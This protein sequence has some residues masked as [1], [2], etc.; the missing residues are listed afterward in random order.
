MSADHIERIG[1]VYFATLKVP[2][3]LRELLGRHKFK[4]TT[5]TG[6]RRRAKEIAAPIVAAWKAAI[7]EARG[8]GDSAIIAARGIRSAYLAVKDAH[9]D[10]MESAAQMALAE[11]I[12]ARAEAMEAAGDAEG[13]ARFA[14]VA[15]GQGRPLQDYR[16]GWAAANKH[17]AL[18]TQEQ[19]HK[20]VD[21]LLERFALLED[22]TH[23]A[24]RQWV[25]ELHNKGASASSLERMVSFWRSFWRFVTAQEDLG[26]ERQPFTK[27][28]LPKA[29]RKAPTDVRQPFAPADVV[30]LWNAAEEGGD[31]RLADLIRLAAYS[32]ARI[33]ELCSLKLADVSAK[34]F[35]IR[36]AKTAAGVREVPIHSALRPVVARLSKRAKEEG[37]VYLI[38]GLTFNKYGDRSNAIGK[39]F[40]RLKEAQGFGPQHVFHSIRKT[41]V[42]LLE[43]A[44]V[45][46]NLAADIVGHDK[47]RMTYGLYSGGATLGVKAQALAMVAYPV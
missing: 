25:R 18:K 1:D 33:E 19:M 26:P 9:P 3:E 39:R 36:E 2:K 37:E 47:P 23:A 30:K 11:H 45:S 7:R 43:N 13:A 32:G 24:V 28:E 42:T 46:E 38:P 44:G 12:A 5:K 20:D 10:S 34:S 16:A 4:Q 15:T 14:K 17:L 21:T 27:I 8:Q 22:V 41:V 40:G 29:S 31:W 35:T 6:D